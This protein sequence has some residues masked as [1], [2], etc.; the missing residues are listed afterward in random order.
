MLKIIAKRF[1]GLV[2]VFFGITLVS[3]FVIHLAP[4]K[5]TDIQTSLN[6]KVSYEARLRLEKLY[7]L[8]KPIHVQYLDWLRRVRTPFLTTD[9]ARLE[10]R[11][12][13]GGLCA[14]TQ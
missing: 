5:P 2:P 3:F 12:P 8:D 9:P 1:M 13:R 11:P 4:G 10:V 6:P 7:G 14:R